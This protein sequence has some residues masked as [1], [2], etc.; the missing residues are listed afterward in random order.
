MTVNHYIAFTGGRDYADDAWVNELMQL[1]VWLYGPELRVIH[2]AARGADRL[3]KEACE[4]LGVRVKPF[5]A[6]WESAPRAAGHIR[7]GVMA[8]FLADK[9]DEGH[10][11]QCIALP[12]GSGTSSMIAECEKRQIAVDRL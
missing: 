1:L 7:N 9:R 5:P 4:A 8:Q 3:V 6:D 10:T 11:C 12:G 2:G